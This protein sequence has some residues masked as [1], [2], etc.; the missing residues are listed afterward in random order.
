MLKCL[1]GR[2]PDGSLAIILSDCHNIG[3]GHASQIPFI[4][5]LTFLLLP[6]SIEYVRMPSDDVLSQPLPMLPSPEDALEPQYEFSKRLGD[7]LSD[8]STPV[9]D[10]SIYPQ[11]IY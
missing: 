10:E 9:S 6:G 8:N 2:R 1:A 11:A 4:A 7:R 3:H 5:V